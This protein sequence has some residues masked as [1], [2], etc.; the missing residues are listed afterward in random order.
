MKHEIF[1]EADKIWSRFTKDAED[2]DVSV[3]LKIHKKLLSLFHVGDYYYY[4]FN[5]KTSSFELMS[6]DIYRVLGYMP[7]EVDVPFFLSKIHPEDQPYFLNFENKVTEF[8]S[9]LKPEQILNYKVSY[10]Y[11]IQ[12]KDSTYIR[13]LQQVFT[14]QLKEDN[15]VIKTF[16]FHTNISHL[17][18]TGV[19]VLSF[20]G[21]NGEVSYMDVNVKQVFSPSTI[22]LTSREREV[23]ALLMKG[24][25]SEQ[26]SKEL[27]ISKLTVDTHRKNILRKTA[28][29]NTAG[30]VS[31]AVKNGWL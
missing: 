15:Q 1:K 6:E 5:I 9:S 7:E 3:P 26:I 4:V 2:K 18:Q 14:I 30:L 19:P 16:G 28:C 31:E 8:F 29:N 25:K 21:L 17:K 11:R 27:F 13:I 24:K 20:I 10:D 22:S 23:L 12:K